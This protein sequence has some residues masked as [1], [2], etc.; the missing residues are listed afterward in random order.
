MKSIENT[1]STFFLATAISASMAFCAATSAY[2]QELSSPPAPTDTTVC[3]PVN[4]GVFDARVHVRCSV[5]VS[6]VFY[7]AASTSNNNRAARIL[8]MLSTA[9]AASHDVRIY[10][11]P[12]DTSGTSIGCAASDCR[13]IQSVELL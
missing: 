12:A 1:K 9:V 7:F 11:D 3:T 4:V 2:A 5:G 13:L 6:G 8:A 10:Y